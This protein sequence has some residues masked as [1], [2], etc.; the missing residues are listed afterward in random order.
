MP[1]RP[2]LREDMNQPLVRPD[3]KRCP[4]NSPDLLPIHVLLLHHTK[5]IAD[6]LV[7]ISKECVRQVVLGLELGL[8]LGR[9]ARDSEH[10]SARSLELFEGNPE[11]AGL[12]RTAWSICSRIED[13]FFWFAFF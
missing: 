4:F 7:Y 5:L 10:H 8:S 1:F 6:F 9:V 12:N 2:H 3:Q 11:P 13:L